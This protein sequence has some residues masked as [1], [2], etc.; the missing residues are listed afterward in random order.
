MEMLRFSKDIKIY[1]I[2]IDVYIGKIKDM[3]K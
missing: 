1:V 2:Y 3:E